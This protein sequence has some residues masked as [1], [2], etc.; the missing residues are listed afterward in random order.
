MPITL[1]R[2]GLMARTVA[3]RNLIAPTTKKQQARM[4]RGEIEAKAGEYRDF[5]T[6]EDKRRLQA[7]HILE[8]RRMMR[9]L[10]ID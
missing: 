10:G 5:S 1:P 6:D 2:K 3:Q 7:M 8:D 9:E 4:E